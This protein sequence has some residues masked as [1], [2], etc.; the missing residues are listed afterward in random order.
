[1]RFVKQYALLHK[2]C[3]HKHIMNERMVFAQSAQK[4]N[5]RADCAPPRRM[6]SRSRPRD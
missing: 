6:I 2:H 3:L 1:M 5:I 4:E